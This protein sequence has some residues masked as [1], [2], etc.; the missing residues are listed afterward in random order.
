MGYVK[1]N[2]NGHTVTPN[3][4]I[5]LEHITGSY[6]PAG[7]EAEDV[8]HLLGGE[9]LTARRTL[10][11][12]AEKKLLKKRIIKKAGIWGNMRTARKV[13]VFY[14]PDQEVL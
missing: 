13:A 12:L 5:L 9:P 1:V 6:R 10:H 8:R 14:V 2:W 4:K 7:V 3:E 11:S